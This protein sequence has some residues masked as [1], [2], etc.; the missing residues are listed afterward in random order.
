MSEQS[1]SEHVPNYDLSPTVSVPEA[2]VLAGDSAIVAELLAQ[3]AARHARVVVL[4]LYH[5]VDEQCLVEGV[6]ARLGADEVIHTDEAKLPEEVIAEK[7]HCFIT[8]DRVNGM[9]STCRI[10]EFFDP[11]AVDALRERVSRA[12]CLTVVWGVAA[13]VVTRGDLLVYCDLDPEQVRA[14]YAAGMGN[15]GAGNEGE[16]YLRKEKRYVFLESRVQERHKRPLLSELDYLIDCADPSCLRMVSRASLE[17]IFDAVVSQPFEL[18][19]YFQ[20]GVW[21]GHWI[22]DVLGGGLG[23]RNTAWGMTGQFDFQA[24]Q[25]SCSGGTLRLPARDVLLARPLDLVGGQVFFQYGYHVPVTMDLL[26]TVGGGN[27]SLQV[28]PTVAYD[29]EVFNAPHGH[30]ESYY[31][32][33]D[34]PD[35]SVYLGLKEG[36][37]VRDFVSALERAQ[38]TGEFDES[39]WVN[40]WPVKKHDHLFIPSG[41]VHCSGAGTLVLEINTFWVSTFKLWDWGRVDFDGRPRPIDI[42]RGAEV[43][44]ESFTTSFARDRLISRRVEVDRGYGWRKE[45][46]GLMEY[47]PLHVERYWFSKAL[48]IETRETIK[49]LCLVEGDEAELSSPNGEFEPRV[50]H[51]AEPV[52][53]PARVGQV[54]V[55]PHGCPEGTELA[56]LEAYQDLGSRYFA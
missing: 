14:R 11:A 3:V 38:G 34:T 43:I 29:R 50:V 16:E 49:L 19:P 40:R 48:L 36:V 56:I 4:D 6:I 22:K 15:W 18:V 47:E 26:D 37:R 17:K 27:L 53:V 2:Q 23:L 45:H 31:I 42:D 10:E 12:G 28:H 51:Y 24:L 7:F 44:Q 46:S 32:L 30:Y 25:A 1:Q 55:R 54:L 41:T 8:D 5:G 20:A 33:D 13:S 9:M 21:G 39:A 35:S 52:F